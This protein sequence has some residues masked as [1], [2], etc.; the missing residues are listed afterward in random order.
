MA[1]E[2][3]ALSNSVAPEEPKRPRMDDCDRPGSSRISRD[4]GRRNCLPRQDEDNEQGNRSP[5]T[6]QGEEWVANFIFGVFSAPS[7]RHK[8][9]LQNCDV[10]SVFRH[11]VEPLLWS[12]IPI[13]F[14]LRD[15]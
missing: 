10:N 9:K 11:P 5:G 12:E 3:R 2:C 13:T 8:I 1:H 14:D 4:R 7:C 15:H 6:F